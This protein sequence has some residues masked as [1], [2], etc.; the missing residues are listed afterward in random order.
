MFGEDEDNGRAVPSGNGSHKWDEMLWIIKGDQIIL[1]IGRLVVVACYLDDL[2]LRRVIAGDAH[3]DMELRIDL[4]VLLRR[5]ID[6][7]G[8]PCRE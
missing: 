4:S 2:I 6:R 7:L 5:K 3:P 8:D 1:G